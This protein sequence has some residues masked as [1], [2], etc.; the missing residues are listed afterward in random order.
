MGTGAALRITSPAGRITGLDMTGTQITIGRPTDDQAPDLVLAPDPQRWIGRLHCTLDRTDGIW[1][2]IDNTSVNG[3][4]LR[5][6]ESL[7]RIEGRRRIEH[8]DTILILGD[9][10]GDGSPL[11]W[12]L[13]FLDPH[14]TRPAPFGTP[15][16]LPRAGPCLRYDWVA[17]RA[18]RCDG[19][20]V[21]PV[22]G[23]RPQGHQLL[24]Y[25]AGRS[26][27]GAAVACDH[28]ELITALWGER[29]EWAPHRSYTR[30][31]LA[32]VVMAT[33]RCIEPV[34]AAP[35]ILET[36]TGLGYRLNVCQGAP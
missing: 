12:E 15:T 4:L 10:T 13:T 25:M 11:Y 36:V 20:A 14:T 35:Q 31:D 7:G 5:H 19:A 21:T 34:P 9:M 33:R 1:S 24:R 27:G 3:T 32:G 8:G 6:G 18:Y 22:E 28:R 17:A 29:D 30:A 2:V 23:L 26:R 16:E